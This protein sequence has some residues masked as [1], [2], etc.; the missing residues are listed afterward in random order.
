MI[1]QHNSR[2][3]H[4]GRNPNK[5]QSPT[6]LTEILI[7]GIAIGIIVG[8]TF[9]FALGSQPV[10]PRD[11][12]DYDDEGNY[13]LWKTPMGIFN[14]WCMPMIITE[15]YPMTLEAKANI[16]AVIDKSKELYGDQ[17]VRV[18]EADGHWNC[19]NIHIFVDE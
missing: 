5:N 14:L 10:D 12:G 2:R 16:Q 11:L 8:I 4:Y 17:W 7:T 18:V 6:Y 9:L 1:K 15:K 19:I 13:N 3:S